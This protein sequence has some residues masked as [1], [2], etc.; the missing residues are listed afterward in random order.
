MRAMNET[1]FYQI[2]EQVCMEEYS[3]T[4]DVSVHHFS[5]RHRRN[6]KHIL[7]L[8]YSVPKPSKKLKLNRRKVL[9]LI[10]A[11]FL[12][13]VAV[14]GAVRIYFYSSFSM[15]EH[16]DNTQLF[17]GNASG[18]PEVIEQVYCLSKL[19]EG[20]KEIK[21][22]S[23]N[24]SAWTIYQYSD[25]VNKTIVL[26]QTVKKEFDHH[27]K[28]EGYHFE[29]VEINGHKGLFIDWSINDDISCEAVWD[30]GEY[31]FTVEGN[32]PKIAL[33]N[34]AKSAKVE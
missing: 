24:I 28:T 2:L 4:G 20:Y 10:A 33:L 22:V 11:I 3:V 25:D 34:L 14:T 23:D 30:N 6:M 12:A 13:V 31:I 29:E 5:L 8:P 21:R 18:V 9:I 17:V 1:D 27:F 16:N 32:L 7:A 15:K 26:T 19:P